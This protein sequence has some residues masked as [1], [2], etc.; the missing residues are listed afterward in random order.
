[1]AHCTFRKPVSKSVTKNQIYVKSK[2]LFKEWPE[3]RIS[4]TPKK[5]NRSQHN[6]EL[7][8]RRPIIM[9]VAYDGRR[10]IF[11]TGKIH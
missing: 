9:S 3:R 11:S 1:L 4:S 6:L 5:E 2:L 8:L 10:E 7:K